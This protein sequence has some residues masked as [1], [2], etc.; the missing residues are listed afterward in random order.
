VQP[1]SVACVEDVPSLTVIRQVGELKPVRLIE[2]RPS[3]AA[4]PI[5]MPSIVIVAPAWAP[6]PSTRS[7]LPFS[8]AR[9][10]EIAA[11]AAGAATRTNTVPSRSART[12]RPIALLGSYDADYETVFRG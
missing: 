9:V 7:S 1:E 8:S 12:I 3:E 5:A 4:V 10:T 2:K 11:S 6:C